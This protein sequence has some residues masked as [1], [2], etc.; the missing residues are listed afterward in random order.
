MRPLAFVLLLALAAPAPALERSAA[1]APGSAGEVSGPRPRLLF[2]MRGRRD[3][4]VNLSDWKPRGSLQ[5]NITGLE[6]KGVIE[7]DGSVAA[8]FINSDDRILYTLRGNRLYGS[9]QKP[10]PGVTGRLID[11]KGAALRQGELSLAFSAKR[12]AKRKF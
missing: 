12:V 4:F 7:V 9:S 11:G 8:L 3:P 1:E 2:N 6:F 10:V 5:F